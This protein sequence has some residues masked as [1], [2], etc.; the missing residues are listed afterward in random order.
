M[1]QVPRDWDFD[2]VFEG[3]ELGCGQLLLDLRLFISGLAAGQRLL[4]ASRDLA[5]PVEIPAWCRMT[6]HQLLMA[7]PPYYLIQPKPQTKE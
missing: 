4:V 1:C 7:K 2:D 3:L 5:S 6:G